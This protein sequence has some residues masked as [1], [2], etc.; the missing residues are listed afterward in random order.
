MG[1]ITKERKFLANEINN[2]DS[3]Q[4][5]LYSSSKLVALIHLFNVKQT[6]VQKSMNQKPMFWCL[7]CYP[8][9]GD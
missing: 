7:C 4:E 5:F 9:F 2:N 6:F 8:L 1:W 3:N